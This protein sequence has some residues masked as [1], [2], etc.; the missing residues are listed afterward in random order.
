MCTYVYMYVYEH[1]HCI[2]LLFL[3]YCFPVRLRVLCIHLF[4]LT[5]FSFLI[6]Q[7][8]L[9]N[10]ILFFTRDFLPICQTRVLEQYVPVCS[11]KGNVINSFWTI[12]SWTKSISSH[13]PDDT[14]RNMRLICFQHTGRG[15]IAFN[16]YIFICIKWS[17]PTERCP[18]IVSPNT[19]WADGKKK[20][21][22]HC[23][24]YFLF[25]TPRPCFQVKLLF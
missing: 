6:P 16:S 25:D 7:G 21:R 4:I 22:E 24:I 19:I 10:F 5:P 1:V 14:S 8:I 13:F 11:R 23:A 20:R 17:F 3:V 12:K 9:C 18:N 15:W 2:P